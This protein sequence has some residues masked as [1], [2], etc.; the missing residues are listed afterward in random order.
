MSDQK[1]KYKDHS[2]N[3]TTKVFSA[4]EDVID[5]LTGKYG[6][7]IVKGDE[8]KHRYMEIECDACASKIKTYPDNRYRR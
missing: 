2:T 7:V 8:C 3:A 1:E 5:N 4:G 6:I